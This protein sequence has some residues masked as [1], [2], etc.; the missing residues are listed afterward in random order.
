MEDLEELGASLITQRSS[1]SP[2]TYEE[3][4]ENEE[5][6]TR[7]LRERL[8]ITKSVCHNNLNKLEELG[9]V[10]GFGKRLKLTQAG[11]ETSPERIEDSPREKHPHF[12]KHDDIAAIGVDFK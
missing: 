7:E 4:W 11:E 6:S 8:N 1:A 10:E 2:E 9:L 5:I 3:V 12:K